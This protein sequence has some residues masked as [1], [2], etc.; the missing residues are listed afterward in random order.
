MGSGGKLHG[1]LEHRRG[2]QK[3]ETRSRP[4]IRS[5]TNQCGAMG[6]QSHSEVSSSEY[7]ED[8]WP[9]QLVAPAARLCRASI[10]TKIQ[11]VRVYAVGFD[12]PPIQHDGPDD[13]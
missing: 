8:T 7:A 6:L 4:P 1:N 13:E 10:V 12:E 9:Q 3:D 2:T 5:M 11:V